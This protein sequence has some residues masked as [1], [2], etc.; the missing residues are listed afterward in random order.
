MIYLIGGPP[1]CGKTT[2]AKTLSKLEGIPW[3]STDTLQVVIKPYID[4]NDYP[5]K[6]PTIYQ[7]GKS[8]DEK[9]SQYSIDEIIQ[10][11]QVQAKTSYPAI[12][13]F[14]ICEIADGNDFI[15]EG[16]HIEP[17]LVAELTLKYPN[18]VKSISLI[19]TDESKFISSIKKSTTPNNWIIERTINEETYSKIAKMICKYGKFFE[20]ESRKYGFKVI[21]MD[22]NFDHQIQEAIKHL[23]NT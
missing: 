1:K 4:E 10:A 14:T 12:D 18:R 23:I 22:N 17:K 6:F 8:N 20:E 2:L 19:K 21:N 5:E 3:I 15:V 7:R 13:M 16:Y 9:Y 11:Y